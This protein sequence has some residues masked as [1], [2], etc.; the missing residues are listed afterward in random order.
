MKNVNIDKVF[1]EL[2]KLYLCAVVGKSKKLDDVKISRIVKKA[3][4]L[5]EKIKLN[6]ALFSIKNAGLD[7]NELTNKIIN[8][9]GF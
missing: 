4:S 3:G 7:V 9:R 6:E 5:N 8:G 1:S 2:G